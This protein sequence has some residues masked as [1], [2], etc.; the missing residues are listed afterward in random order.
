MATAAASTTTTA[1]AS[2]TT[3][4]ATA[5]N[6]VHGDVGADAARVAGR[7][8]SGRRVGAKGDVKGVA[9]QLDRL[10]NHGRNKR[11]GDVGTGSREGAVED[12]LERQGRRLFGGVVLDEQ[13][14]RVRRVREVI[15]S[16]ARRRAEAADV[17]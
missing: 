14:Q 7:G 3:A 13:R 12:S 4:A 10:R 9:A 17:R 16:A 15:G 2:T 8:R 6:L 1:A 11:R 5:G